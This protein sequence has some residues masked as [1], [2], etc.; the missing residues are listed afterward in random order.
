[1]IAE[2]A[3]SFRGVP[4]G[5]C[6]APIAVSAKVVSPADE[7]EDDDIHTPHTFIARCRLCEHEDIYAVTA[8]RTFDRHPRSRKARA[9]SA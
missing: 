2:L 7:P 1:M 9:A 8:V 4:C 3:R 6:N 5:R